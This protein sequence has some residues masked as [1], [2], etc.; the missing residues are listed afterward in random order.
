[1]GGNHDAAMGLYI[2]KSVSVGPFRFNLSGSGVGVSVGMP[3]FRI[4]ASPR[5]N[6]IHM[7]MGGV[8][9]RSTIPKGTSK[10]VTPRRVPDALPRSDNVVM[11]EIESADALTIV[12]IDS[13]ALVAEMDAKRRKLRIWPWVVAAGI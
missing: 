2:R 5:G 4:G 1:M 6:Y 11:Q 3:G 13:A 8:Y 12:D 10:S 7:G 9:Y